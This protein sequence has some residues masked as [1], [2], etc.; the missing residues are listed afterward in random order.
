[1]SDIEMQRTPSIT[2]SSVFTQICIINRL[3]LWTQA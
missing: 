1:M 3:F 2:K